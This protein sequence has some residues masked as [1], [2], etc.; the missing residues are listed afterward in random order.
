MVN[1]LKKAARR[2]NSW[3]P[4]CLFYSCW[5]TLPIKDSFCLPV[6]LYD[7]NPQTGLTRRLIWETTDSFFLLI[8]FFF[9][10]THLRTLQGKALRP[11]VL[12]STRHASSRS[13]LAQLCSHDVPQNRKNVAGETIR[14]GF[15]RKQRIYPEVT[16]YRLR[17]TGSGT[18]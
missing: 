10:K 17:I 4:A 8:F 12:T 6:L 11:L 18:G 3:Y 15:S 16:F 5:G 13:V 1:P 9:L 2:Q 14:G 7:V